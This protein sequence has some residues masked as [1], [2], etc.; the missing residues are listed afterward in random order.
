M[1]L[2]RMPARV[3]P[4]LGP[5]PWWKSLALILVPALILLVVLFPYESASA[6]TRPTVTGIAFIGLPNSGDTFR[7]REGIRVL[8]TFDKDVTVDRSLLHFVGLE[9]GSRKGL[10][11]YAGGIGGLVVFEYLVVDGDM[12]ADGVS[13][14]ANAIVGTIVDAT[15]GTTVAVLTH[16]A[17]P[18]DPLRKV[19]GTPP[20]PGVTVWPRTRT[21]PEGGTASYQV[22]LD[23]Q[24]RG[25][26][27][28]SV[29][30]AA[31]SD[32]DLGATPARLTFTTSNW[33]TGQ[34]V[35]VSA[36]DDQDGTVGTAT[37]RHTATSTD[38]EYSG[39]EIADV[40]AAEN[41]DEYAH[42]IPFFP[43]A[44]T[45]V[46][47]F[48]RIINRSDEAGEVYIF[49]ID[50]DGERHG[51]A[52]LALSRETLHDNSIGVVDTGL[53]RTQDV[54]S[55]ARVSRFDETGNPLGDDDTPGE[56]H[57][58]WVAGLAAG[59]GNGPTRRGVNP[60]SALVFVDVERARTSF[61]GGLGCKIGCAQL[62]VRDQHRPGHQDRHQ[63]GRPGG[64]RLVGR[65]VEVFRPPELQAFLGPQLPARQG[66][67]DA[68]RPREGRTRRLVLRRQ[69]RESAHS[70]GLFGTAM[71][72]PP[73]T[74]V[75]SPRKGR[76]GC[77]RGGRR[78]KFT[79]R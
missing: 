17:V 41:D 49:G 42:F 52:R 23:S 30:P 53:P 67:R 61:L 11:W 4:L 71:F 55:E 46:Q 35:T 77:S 25:P 3:A 9:I 19:D 44:S 29:T 6:Q 50:D 5:K 60:H 34:T 33:S 20:E 22:A 26:V 57:G 43:S 15:D 13:I 39:I 14:R 59:Y 75:A 2:G 66:R 65:Q 54:L 64:E 18:D 31:D 36:A 24:P 7:Q 21:V 12:D 76:A 78:R 37:F 27:T 56:T 1:S 28:V 48:A 10:A 69:L 72:N 38:P 74:F 58:L 51:P 47:G 16:D 45:A 79:A 63:P 62:H 32:P 8:V 70:G 68:L 73:P 40:T